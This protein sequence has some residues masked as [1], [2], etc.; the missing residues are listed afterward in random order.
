MFAETE[1]ERKEDKERNQ[2]LTGLGWMQ[3]LV[4]CWDVPV[5][6]IPIAPRLFGVSL[7]IDCPAWD[8]SLQWGIVSS[9]E[10]DFQNFKGVGK[11]SSYVKQMSLRQGQR[12][13]P[14]PALCI[15]RFIH[16]VCV[17][18]WLAQIHLAAGWGESCTCLEDKEGAGGLG[19]MSRNWRILDST[20]A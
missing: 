6:A 5:F 8:C 14:Q 20:F 13:Q 16:V 17:N 7:K 10:I 15:H 19:V 4:S 3:E 12:K 2:V 1:E 9:Q 18:A 11:S